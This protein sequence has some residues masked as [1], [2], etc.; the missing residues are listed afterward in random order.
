MRQQEKK[1]FSQKE[2]ISAKL[3]EG[4]IAGD[5]AL[6]GTLKMGAAGAALAT[7]AAQE[8]LTGVSF[9]VILAILNSFGV[10]AFAGVGIAEK[11]CA[12][13]FL[14]PG[15]VMSAVSFSVDCVIYYER[16]RQKA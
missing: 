5:F 15:A 4:D 1:S 10:I 7:V 14:V 16:K 3:Q 11:I 13:M 9:I 2:R 8:A 6:V 12:L